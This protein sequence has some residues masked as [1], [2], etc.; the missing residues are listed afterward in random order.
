MKQKDE[1][2]EISI[3][4]AMDRLEEIARR[5]EEPEIS[6]KESLAIYTEG[7]NLVQECKGHLADVEKEMIIL[8]QKGETSDQ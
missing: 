8:E 7:V 2:K 4:K 5:L 3:E 1:E 6:L